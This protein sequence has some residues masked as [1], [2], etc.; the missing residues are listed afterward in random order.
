MVE[1]NQHKDKQTEVRME[2][3]NESKMRFA[4]AYMQLLKDPKK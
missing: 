1:E 4:F 3:H 2:G